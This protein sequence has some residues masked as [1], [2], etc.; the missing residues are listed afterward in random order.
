MFQKVFRVLKVDINAK[1]LLLNTQKA[2]DLKRIIFN[3]S[4]E[5]HY[6]ISDL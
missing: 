5:H 3:M 4:I 1:K 2:R 6:Q